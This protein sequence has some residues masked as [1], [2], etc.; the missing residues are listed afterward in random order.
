MT[1]RSFHRKHD[2]T[3]SKYPTSNPNPH[4]GD[5]C[6][7]HYWLNDP[8]RLDLIPS[9]ILNYSILI[10]WWSR[11]MCLQHLSVWEVCLQRSVLLKENC[12]FKTTNFTGFHGELVKET[13]RSHLILKI[14]TGISPRTDKRLSTHHVSD[15]I[16]ASMDVVT[17]W[18]NNLSAAP[19]VGSVSTARTC[20]VGDGTGPC[21]QNAPLTAMLW[22]KCHVF[23][24]IYSAYYFQV[25]QCSL[26]FCAF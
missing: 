22:Y 26:F 3:L 21:P 8:S 23:L 15:S 19:C 10:V 12:A 14:H 20:P 16:S 7:R 13:L 18:I 5:G 17:T 6:M 25:H 4:T 11:M 9:L 24:K 2:T 1:C